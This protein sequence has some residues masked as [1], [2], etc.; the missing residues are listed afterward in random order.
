VDKIVIKLLQGS[1]VTQT[2]VGGLSIHPFV[3]NFMWCE[4]VSFCA[5]H[6]TMSVIKYADYYHLLK[7]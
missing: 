3:E 4:K 2:V 7:S 1:V 6:H 5:T